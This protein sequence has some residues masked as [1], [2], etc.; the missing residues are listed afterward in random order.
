MENN[1]E[2][3]LINNLTHTLKDEINILKSLKN[4]IKNK[5]NRKDSFSSDKFCDIQ[6]PVRDRENYNSESYETN[7]NIYSSFN[8]N[9]NDREDLDNSHVSNLSKMCQMSE[10][11]NRSPA[12]FSEL[13]KSLKYN[14]SKIN[15]IQKNIENILRS[16]KFSNSVNLNNKKCI[17]KNNSMNTLENKNFEFS[18][19]NINSS[20]YKYQNNE[21]SESIDREKLIQE[22]IT[23][24]SDCMIYR[25]D[26]NYLTEINKNLEMEMEHIRKKK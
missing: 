24:K 2:P 13:E 1:Q 5:R 20:N 19:L 3:L 23:L 14:E 15:D 16:G 21:V 25:E 7:K 12:Q 9:N 11:V 22:N 8:G 10:I 18:N 17:S 6:R 26:I 4:K